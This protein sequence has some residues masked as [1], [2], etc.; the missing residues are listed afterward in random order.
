MSICQ[1]GVDSSIGK[2]SKCPREEEGSS[3]TIGTLVGALPAGF[4]WVVV[5]DI[6]TSIVGGDKRC[7]CVLN[8]IVKEERLY[9]TIKEEQIGGGCCS[10]RTSVRNSIRNAERS[11]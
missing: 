8:S 1:V 4:L 7:S 5:A 2:G 3:L 11:P 6:V 9:S 10:D